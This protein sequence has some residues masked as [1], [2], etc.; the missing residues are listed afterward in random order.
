M[1]R[2]QSAAAAA[3]STIAADRADR[4]RLMTL[5]WAHFLNDGAANYLPGVLPA[6]LIS[7]NL[8]VSYAG[9]FMAALLIGQ[10]AQPLTGLIADRVGGRTFIVAGLAGAAAGGGLVGVM[11]TGAA[12]IVVLVF[13]G[14]CNSLFHPQALAAVRRIG[15]ARGGASMSIF[16]V[17]GEIGR[18][19]WPLIATWLVTTRGLTALWLLAV[20]AM[21]TLPAL[22]FYAPRL[23]ARHPE[24]APP[25]LRAHAGPLSRLVGFCALRS[26]MILSIVTYMPLVWQARGGSLT[27][28]ASFITVLLLVGIIG[29]LGGGRLGDRAGARP[30]II[31]AICIGVPLLAGFILS[32]GLAT[33]ILLALLGIA[34]FATL[35]LTVLIAQDVLPESRSLGSGLALGFANALGALGVL[36]LGPV[37]DAFGPAMALWAALAGGIIAVPLAVSLPKNQRPDYGK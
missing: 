34:L 17:G 18:G 21:L 28:G 23:P 24:A 33:W 31:A 37:A 26:V 13:T 35:P 19:A 2:R 11:P 22:Y 3:T 4:P 9:V 7:L 25:D 29:N 12:L 30:V 5:G 20:P 36:A 14:L 16:L 15:G 27:G 6:I 10:A 32:A 1:R 8:S